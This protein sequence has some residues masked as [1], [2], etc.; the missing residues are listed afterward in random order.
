MNKVKV[1]SEMLSGA[2]AAEDAL[3]RKETRELVDSIPEGH[4]LHD[5][6]ER[7]KMM[8]G[9]D[10]EGLPPSHPLYRAMA[11]AKERFEAEAEEEDTPSPREEAQEKAKIKKAKRID[12]KKARSARIARE[13][14]SEEHLNTATKAVDSGIA[15]ALDSLK[16]LYG[17]LAEHEEILNTRPITKART[18]RLKRFLFATEK[19]LSTSRMGRG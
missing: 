9:G 8:T 10:L 15:S 4:I 11:A 6:I 16:R 2:R 14:E 5:E 12:E 19:G 1:S 18:L 13:V 17:L 7:Q 3:A